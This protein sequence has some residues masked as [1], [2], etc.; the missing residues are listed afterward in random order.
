MTSVQSPSQ[1][2]SGQTTTVSWSLTNQGTGIAIGQPLHVGFAPTQPNVPA[3]PAQSTWDETIYMSKSQS[4]DAS[5]VLL[6]TFT[7][8]GALR[9][10]GQ[11]HRDRVGQAA[12][13]HQRTVLLD[14]PAGS[15]EAGF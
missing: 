7:H 9:P 10:G 6:Q 14:R 5:A 2:F 13:R 12:G 1:A 15:L 11:F 4:I 3:T 8:N